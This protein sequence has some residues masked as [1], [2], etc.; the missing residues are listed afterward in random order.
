MGMP[1]AEVHGEVHNSWR[2]MPH[3]KPGQLRAQVSELAALPGAQVADGALL[4][5]V[6]PPE[7]AAA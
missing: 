7:A 5:V 4:A 3:A 2:P 6:A 1:P